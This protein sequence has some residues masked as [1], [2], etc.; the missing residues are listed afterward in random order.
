[1]ATDGFLFAAITAKCQFYSIA[2]CISLD[3]HD[4]I[5]RSLQRIAPVSFL[6]F[7]LIFI[8]S[9]L[10][11][12]QT[13]EPVFCCFIFLHRFYQTIRP[14]FQVKVASFIDKTDCTVFETRPNTLLF[15]LNH[16]KF[17]A[18]GLDQQTCMGM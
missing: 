5:W 4:R 6:G 2:F 14:P 16:L 13:L 9:S 8:F 17:I 12:A 7:P 11:M 18:I 15:N 1:M 10:K 3:T